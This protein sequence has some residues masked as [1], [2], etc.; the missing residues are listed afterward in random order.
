MALGAL[1]SKAIAMLDR[2]WNGDISDRETTVSVREQKAAKVETE[3]N[4]REVCCRGA[5][6][7]LLRDWPCYACVTLLCRLR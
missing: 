2:A 1:E 6:S 7:S 3:L 5:A 4:Q